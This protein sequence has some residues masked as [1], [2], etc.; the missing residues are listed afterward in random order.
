MEDRAT[1][2]DKLSCADYHGEPYFPKRSCTN[3]DHGNGIAF[4]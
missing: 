3:T 4:L 2:V 1:S